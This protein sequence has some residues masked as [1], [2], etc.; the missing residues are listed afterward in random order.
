MLRAISLILFVYSSTMIVHEY[1][2]PTWL[3]YIVGIFI[4]LLMSVKIKINVVKE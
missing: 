2:G 4:A 1:S 3:T